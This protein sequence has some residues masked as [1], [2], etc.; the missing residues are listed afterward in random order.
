[1]VAVS[2]LSTRS[3]KSSVKRRVIV[4]FSW[5]QE[6]GSVNDGISADNYLGQE[7]SI[8]Y[9][10]VDLLCQRAA[11][12]GT[13]C[14]GW[15]RDMDLAFKQLICDPMDWP[16]MGISWQSAIFFDKTVVMGCRSVPYCCQ[17]T[18]NFI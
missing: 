8:I 17:R 14:L 16:L 9:P 10:T 3:K 15:K 4:D 1:M 6:G 5:P 18:T 7:I 13:N 12:L 2:P 11:R